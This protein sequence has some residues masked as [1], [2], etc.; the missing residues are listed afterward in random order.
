M[1]HHHA[2]VLETRLVRR[3]DRQCFPGRGGGGQVGKRVQGGMVRPQRVGPLRDGAAEPVHHP[4]IAARLLFVRIEQRESAMI[5]RQRRK[6][7]RVIEVPDRLL[8]R[9]GMRVY[10]VE[11]VRQVPAHE[12]GAEEV[13]RSRHLVRRRRHPQLHAAEE[14]VA[15][16]VILHPDEPR[17]HG[18]NLQPAVAVKRDL[19][20]SRIVEQ[21]LILGAVVRIAVA[22]DARE[23][24]RGE[25]DIGGELLRR[26]ADYEGSGDIQP[27]GFARRSVRK[28]GRRRVHRSGILRFGGSGQ[29][30]SGQAGKEH[31]PVDGD[32]EA[33]GLRAPAERIGRR[34]GSIDCG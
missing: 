1:H 23:A 7:H 34:G 22:F 28:I 6:R 5:L 18:W 3:H 9:R 2:A 11:I 29:E 24:G 33:P 30:R 26:I 16:G 8:R 14:G 4:H 27:A 17:P 10:V 13:A 12:A 25:Q 31:P 32:H 19:L 21:N 15:A 20:A